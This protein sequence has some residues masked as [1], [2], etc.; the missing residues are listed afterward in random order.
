M[1]SLSTGGAWPACAWNDS[2][3]AYSGLV[4]MSPNTTPS[5]PSVSIFSPVPVWPPWSIRRPD[6][7]VRVLVRPSCEPDFAARLRSP[8]HLHAS[9][10]S[11]PWS[12]S[13]QHRS[14]PPAC[15]DRNA[16]IYVKSAWPSTCREPF[17]DGGERRRSTPVRS[18]SGPT[19]LITA[20][21][22][23]EHGLPGTWVG[24]A[25]G[26]QDRDQQ[27]DDDRLEPDRR[28]FDVD[29][30]PHGPF[31]LAAPEGD[32]EP[33]MEAEFGGESVQPLGPGALLAG[34]HASRQRMVGQ[35][36]EQPGEHRAEIAVEGSRQQLREGV[37][38]E[39]LRRRRPP[40]PR[41]AARFDG[42]YA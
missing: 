25:A 4:P 10:P 29:V 31:D 22:T 24:L 42:K 35:R 16:S 18:S 19:G 28:Q 8:R 41:R 5:A 7:I 6:H 1:L 32:R 15:G 14:R 30:G 17:V 23:D 26:L 13:A 34:Q 27:R 39:A 36:C 2:R 21:R 3:S 9:W 38:D 11:G 37:G 33:G 20:S 12:D 40:P